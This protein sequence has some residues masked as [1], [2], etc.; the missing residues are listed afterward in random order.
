[1]KFLKCYPLE[2]PQKL[3]IRIPNK[4]V[5]S[6]QVE[7]QEQ[8]LFLCFWDFCCI[9]IHIMSIPLG[10]DPSDPLGTTEVKVPWI[11]PYSDQCRGG[12]SELGDP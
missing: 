5:S 10:T 6:S 11:Q 4:Q 12:P 9:F 8:H 3:S 2:I 1:M 7:G